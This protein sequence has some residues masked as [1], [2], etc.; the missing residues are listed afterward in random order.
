M[1][2]NYAGIHLLCEDYNKIIEKLKKLFGQ[3]KE[4][5]QNEAMALELL[6][7]SANKRIGEIQGAKEKAEKQAGIVSF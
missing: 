3:K 7:T 6:T 4:L 1:S 5:R 2:S